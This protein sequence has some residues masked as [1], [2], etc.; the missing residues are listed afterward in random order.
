MS[1]KPKF[2]DETLQQNVEHVKDKGKK[3]IAELANKLEKLVVEYVPCD[4]IKPNEYNPNR[5]S[6]HE[7]E[8]LLDSMRLNGFDQPIIVQRVTRTIVDG[9]HRWRAARKLGFKEIPVVFVDMTPEQQTVATLSHNRARGTEDVQLT[10]ELLRDLEK[11]GALAFAQD[12]L[13]LDDVEIQR[14]INDIPAPEALAAAEFSKPWTP[15]GLGVTDKDAETSMSVEAADR[16]R[17]QQKKIDKAKT[18]ED[19][20]AARKDSKIATF[21]LIYTDKEA[22]I[23]KQVLGKRPAQKVLELCINELG[24]PKPPES[25]IRI[26]SPSPTAS[27]SS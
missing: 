9:E 19:R 12:Q 5:Q 27:H 8:M 25:E 2:P 21:N 26:P 20:E 17:V 11:M 14:L 6:E 4:S 23:V 15:D 3:K 18:E 7:F 24:C 22:E 16:I 13:G 1:E 10:A